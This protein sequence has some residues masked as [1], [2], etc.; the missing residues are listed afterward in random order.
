MYITV[1][2]TLIFITS[3]DIIIIIIIVIAIIIIII[4]TITITTTGIISGSIVICIMVV[5][6]IL[7]TFQKQ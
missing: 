5:K 3:I 6:N 2:N 7:F 1:V 4:I